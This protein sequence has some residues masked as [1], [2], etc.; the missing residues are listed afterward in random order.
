LIYIS[1]IKKF[2]FINLCINNNFY[3]KIPYISEAYSKNLYDFFNEK[4]IKWFKLRTLLVT[5][6]L[7]GDGYLLEMFT[8]KPFL[9]IKPRCDSMIEPRNIF[10]SFLNYKNN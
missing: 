2:L 1:L 10:L 8:K 9:K 3:V 6:N 7:F 4:K 5:D